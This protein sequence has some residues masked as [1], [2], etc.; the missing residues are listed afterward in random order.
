M[1]LGFVE[2]QHANWPPISTMRFQ[3]KRLTLLGGV[4][5][6]LIYSFELSYLFNVRLL[7]ALILTG[8]SFDQNFKYDPIMA[9]IAKGG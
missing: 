9:T 4:T 5:Q 8:L 7:F 3:S 2:A 1:S 6:T